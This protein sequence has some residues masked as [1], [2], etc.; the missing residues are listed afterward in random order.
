MK[1]L[2]LLLALVPFS[3]LNA[4]SWISQATG[5]TAASR[6]LDQIVALDA[7]TVWAKAYDGSGAGAEVQEFTLTT[8]GGT[9]WTPGVI[10]VGDPALGINNI[11]P[12]NS[13]TAWVSAVNPTDGS[14]SVVFKTSNGGAT[15]DQQNPSAFTSSGS[16]VNFVHFFDAN[17][18]FAMGD[19]VGA[20]LEFEIWTTAD[21]GDSWT[22]VPG[23]NIPNPVNSTEYGLNGGNVVVGNTAWL[24]TNKGRILKSVDMGLTWTVSQAP[25]TD[26][27]GAAQS[28]RLAFS[29]ANNGCLLKTAGTTYTFY[30]TSNG[31]ATWSTGSTFTGSHRLLSYIPGTT[32]IVGT[33]QAAPVGSSYSLNNGLA[34]TPIE[35][36]MQR[37]VS[38]FVNGSTGWCAGF[39]SDA[40][41]DGI[42]KFDGTLANPTFEADA[43]IEVYPN[44]A[45][46]FVT[47]SSQLDSYDLSV[48][49][50]TGKTVLQQSLS[51]IE[52]SVDVSSL[53]SG[54]YL[55]NINS[56]NKKET[57]K[58]IKN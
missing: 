6:G 35:A 5:F 49:D 19:P 3:G 11:C 1:K 7:N 30:T 36:D 47:I 44:P 46:N 12:I 34:W 16:F 41:T 14:G 48:T 4:Q 15:W 22:Q 18:G 23:A 38:S 51:G 25:L 28:G 53:S 55:F 2:L 20:P 21:G 13:T 27:G 31:G 26:F 56:D 33:S 37:G 24:V 45:N 58:V 52:N 17:N 8:N 9:T 32:V 42:F 39:S 10:N 57:I 50:L 40:T 43:A 54:V 29:D